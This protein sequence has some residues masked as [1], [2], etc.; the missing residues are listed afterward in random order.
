VGDVRSTNPCGGDEQIDRA[1]LNLSELLVALLLAGFLLLGVAAPATPRVKTIFALMPVCWD[2]L[3]ASPAL[4]TRFVLSQ[5]SRSTW[6]ANPS[7]SHC[8]RSRP[9]STASTWR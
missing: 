5:A 7:A 1:L 3:K 2:K 8:G 6:D 4:D 9:P